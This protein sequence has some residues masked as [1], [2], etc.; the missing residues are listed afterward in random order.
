MYLQAPKDPK[1]QLPKRESRTHYLGL[2][3]FGCLGI[4]LLGCGGGS[5]T[6]EVSGA[7]TYDGQPV[8]QGQISFIPAS[9]GAAP[10]A[11]T[12]EDGK[13]TV[14]V[15]PG[16][17]RVEIRASRPLPVERQTQPDMGLLYEDYIPAAYNAD[18]KLMA[19]VASQSRK[20]DFHLTP[21]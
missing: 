2:W 7:V 16:E 11:G 14:S 13:Y 8:E 1:T 6:Y 5:T 15:T 10:D 3:V 9:D 21:P 19:D 17:K 4:C 18:S 20:F 12:I